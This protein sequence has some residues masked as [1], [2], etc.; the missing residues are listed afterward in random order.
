[1][2]VCLYLLSLFIQN[3]MIL[4]RT[5]LKSNHLKNVVSVY[6]QYSLI[7]VPWYKVVI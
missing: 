3:L 6:L 5:C 4:F 7:F 1:M 2:F